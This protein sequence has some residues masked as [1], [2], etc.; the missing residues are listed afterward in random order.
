MTEWLKFILSNIS[1]ILSSHMEKAMAPHCSTLAWKIHK[2]AK[3]SDNTVWLVHSNLTQNTINSTM[4]ADKVQESQ[5]PGSL[6][7]TS[8]F[9]KQTQMSLITSSFSGPH[10]PIA[11]YD[12]PIPKYDI[13]ILL[14]SI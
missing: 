1:V 7:C 8:S 9:G 2:S 3:K 14:C 12:I 11:F 6:L 5:A 10:C 4:Q 13:H